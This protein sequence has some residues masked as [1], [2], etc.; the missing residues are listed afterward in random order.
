[1]KKKKKGRDL[2][3]IR[4]PKT[5]DRWPNDIYILGLDWPLK[6]GSATLKGLFRVAEGIHNPMVVTNYYHFFKI[7]N[8]F[9]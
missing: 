6:G 8:Y 5:R 1:M 7:F 4:P 9:F 2:G 3:V